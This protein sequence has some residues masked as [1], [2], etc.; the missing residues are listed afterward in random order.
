MRFDREPDGDVD[1]SDFAVFAA[2]FTGA[3]SAVP[4]NPDYFPGRRREFY[5]REDGAGQTG[6]LGRL[7][8]ALYDYRARE[9]DLWHGR[10]TS[11]DPAEYA[12]SLNLYQY[13]RGNPLGRIDPA[14]T[15]SLGELVS[16]VAR[17]IYLNATIPSCTVAGMWAVRGVMAAVIA[18]NAYLLAT[19]PD[20]LAQLVE[21]VAMY[22]TM[23]GA[24][25]AMEHMAYLTRLAHTMRLAAGGTIEAG[26]SLGAA[27]ARNLKIDARKL[28]HIFGKHASEFGLSGNWN[29]EAAQ[30]MDQ[31]IR[32]LLGKATPISGNFYGTAGTYWYD[33]ATGLFVFVDE[34]MNVLG[35]WM[36]SA[37]Q[38]A[39][40]LSKGWV[41]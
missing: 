5:I 36:L 40:L 7:L 19:Q 20:Y 12:E 30:A 32:S 28:Q 4:A 17:E 14:G 15:F 22:G 11:R 23:P 1:L 13:A 41:R 8:L 16:S 37:A 33:A 26:E 24:T 10:F 25:A 38:K 21:D 35:G 29:N 9:Y 31:A 3:G 18:Y 39:S 34:E 6:Q 2:C 27:V